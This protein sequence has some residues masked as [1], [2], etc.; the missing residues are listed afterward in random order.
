MDSL[1]K[2]PA[3]AVFAIH[4]RSCTVF[5][6]VAPRAAVCW[7]CFLFYP[8]SGL[9]KNKHRKPMAGYPLGSRPE[10]PALAV[11]ANHLR[12]CTVSLPVSPRAA[13]CWHCFLFYPRSGLQKNLPYLQTISD[14]VLFLHQLRPSLCYLALFLILSLKRIAKEQMP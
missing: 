11:F 4:L 6:P 14:F 13:V 7:H 1:P 8:R 5:L 10:F 12:S 3:L 9:Q 2:F